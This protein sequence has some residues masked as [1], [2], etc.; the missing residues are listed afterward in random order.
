MTENRLESQRRPV[1]RDDDGELSTALAFLGF[2]RESLLKKLDGLDDEQVRR[3]LVASDTTLLG[4]VQH[5]T[6]GER[7][8]F[9]HVVAGRGPD[10]HDITF[11]F[12]VPTE[13]SR[14]EVVAAYVA[15]VR[16]SD[17][18]VAAVGDLEA[19]TARPVDDV[20]KSLRWV[21]A[22]MTSEV[23]RHAGHADI[24][25]EGIDESV[26]FMAPG[27]NLPEIDFRAYVERLTALADRF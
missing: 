4:L 14:D 27:H 2:A 13:R 19:T 26:G 15:A 6:D 10:D 11:D 5:C 25:R 1:P 22:H 21:V 12:V 9:E 17:D 3:R 16:A 18:V 24:L 7:Y 8:W 23:A 20:P